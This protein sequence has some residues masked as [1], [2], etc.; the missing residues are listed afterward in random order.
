MPAGSRRR[1]DGLRIQFRIVR[2]HAVVVACTGGQ[3]DI[4]PRA[5][6]S[7]ELRRSPEKTHGCSPETAHRAGG[8]SS[9]DV[10]RTGDRQ[11]K[12]MDVIAVAQASM[13]FLPKVVPT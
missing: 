12:I 11:A 13:L 8:R 5:R 6:V 7:A 1:E 2:R 3:S 4:G 9:N 10:V